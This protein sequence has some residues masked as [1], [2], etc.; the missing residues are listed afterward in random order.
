MD[1]LELSNKPTVIIT[2]KLK[3]QIDYLHKQ[4]GAIEWSGELITSEIKTINDLD[5]WTIICED[6]YLVDI[7]TS[8]FTG[9]EVDKGG[10]KSA[11][12][13]ELYE[14]YP[15]L[16]DGTQKNHHIHTH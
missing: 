14:A 3:K 6:I 10:F 9:Y 11:D 8:G 13:I 5:E 4:C 2:E 15:G 7:G 1:R 12:I 16:M